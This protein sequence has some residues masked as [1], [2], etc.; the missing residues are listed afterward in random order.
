MH[1]TPPATADSIRAMTADEIIVRV[2]A[3][4]RYVATVR[5]TSASLA[6]ELDFSVDEIEELTMGVNELVAVL[7][8]VAEPDVEPWLD[9]VYRLDGDTLEILAT[10]TGPGEGDLGSAEVEVDALA[11]Q[12]LGAVVDEH[13]LAGRSGRILKRRDRA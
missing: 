8:D 2:P 11:T 4:S 6:A 7:I 1:P 9:L 10:L 13:E 3:A 5:V 12:I